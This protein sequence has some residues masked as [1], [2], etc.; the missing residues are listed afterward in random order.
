MELILV[1]ANEDGDLRCEPLK[2]V[3]LRSDG[4]FKA[5]SAKHGEGLAEA[6]I[7]TTT[8]AKDLTCAIGTF[9]PEGLLCLTAYPVFPDRY[10]EVIEQ[11]VEPRRPDQEGILRELRVIISFSEEMPVEQVPEL[12]G[13]AI[14]CVLRALGNRFALSIFL[15]QAH[16]LNILIR[17]V[18]S[19]EILGLLAGE[20][21]TPQSPSVPTT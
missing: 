14:R 15:G 12:E 6:L 3:D 19:D 8:L 16:G 10:V 2:R 1:A 17:E 5:L 9:M 13:N 20:N 11:I 7:R 18:E 21:G 4:G